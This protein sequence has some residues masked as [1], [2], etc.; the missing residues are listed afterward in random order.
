MKLYLDRVG[1][2]LLGINSIILI[3]VGIYLSINPNC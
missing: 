2:A 1:L 3:L